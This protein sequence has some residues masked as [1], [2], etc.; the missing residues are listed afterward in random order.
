MAKPICV[1][2]Y[3]LFLKWEKNIVLLA[4]GGHTDFTDGTGFL[5]IVVVCRG[6]SVDDEADEGGEED[7]G[8]GGLESGERRAESGEPFSWQD[9]E[10]EDDGEDY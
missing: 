3:K 2:R 1:Q 7:E 6:W 5:Y 4:R 8:D 9:G 10:G